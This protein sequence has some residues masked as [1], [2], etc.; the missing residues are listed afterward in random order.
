MP[1]RRRLISLPHAEQRRLVERPAD[2]LHPDRQPRVRKAARHGQR[3]QSRQ[4]GRACVHSPPQVQPALIVSARACPLKPLSSGAATGP[5]GR[6]MTSY[7]S[8]AA[9]SSRR[10]SSLA[11]CARRYAHAGASDADSNRVR[12]LPVVIVAASSQPL[13][14]IRRAIHIGR[15]DEHRPAVLAH[16]QRDFIGRTRHAPPARSPLAA[17]THA[18]P[19]QV[20]RSRT[21][22]SAAQPA[23]RALRH[24]ASPR[25]RERARC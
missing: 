18:H 5:V 21:S 24:R 17:P 22:L 20:P 4:R 15:P 11:L 23:A 19:R 25:S 8:S 9:V 1:L 2:E 7:F 6:M 14:M 3:W 13:R 12:V 16:R 10:I